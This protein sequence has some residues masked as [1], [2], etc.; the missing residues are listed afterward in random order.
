M[1]I[2]RI[3]ANHIQSLTDF[4]VA[5]QGDESSRTNFHPHGRFDSVEEVAPAVSRLMLD[6]IVGSQDPYF[7]GFQDGRPVAYGFL[8][9]WND[10]Y[11]DAFLGVAVHP[12]FQG[13]GFGCEMTWHLIKAARMHGD[14]RVRLTVYGDNERAVRLYR[15]IGFE[16][17]D[18]PA[19]PG[20][21]EGVFW[22][23]R[24]SPDL[25]P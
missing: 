23:R 13:Q 22:F 25:L 21:L 1:R 7:L 18:R 9:G 8:R 20:R 4:M 16:L 10:G 14:A 24:P 17:K 6:K 15:Y 11:Q 19:E 5:I 2:E 3:D 12:D